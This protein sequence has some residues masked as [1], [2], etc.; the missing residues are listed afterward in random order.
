MPCVRAPLWSLLMS[1]LL[2]LLLLL[3]LS[4]TMSSLWQ[5]TFQA[6]SSIIAKPALGPG[7]VYFV[8]S[9]GDVYALEADTG[10]QLVSVG[11]HAAPLGR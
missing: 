11:A 10:L 6:S 5:W 3:S 7:V 1:W 8:T 2:L 9:R 4:L